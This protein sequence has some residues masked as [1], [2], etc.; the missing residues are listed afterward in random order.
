MKNGLFRGSEIMKTFT[1][2]LNGDI[3]VTWQ[4]C[5]YDDQQTMEWLKR[6][7][8]KTLNKIDGHVKFDIQEPTLISESEEE[9]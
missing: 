4:F 6:E 3:R 7:V 8:L 2:S 5:E 9:N 1:F